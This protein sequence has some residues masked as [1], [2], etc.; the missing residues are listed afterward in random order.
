V[1]LLEMTDGLQSKAARMQDVDLEVKQ[2][3]ETLAE[4]DEK[5]RQVRNQGRMQNEIYYL[6]LFNNYYLG[7]ECGSIVFVLSFSRN[8]KC[9]LFFIFFPLL[10]RFLMGGGIYKTLARFALVFFWYIL[11]IRNIC[12]ALQTTNK[13]LKNQVFNK[14][15]ILKKI[16]AVV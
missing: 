1:P 16:D 9:S 5:F 14:K 8:N 13:F 4:Y 12:M 2:L 11:I 6:I 10:R 7:N 3:R 15:K